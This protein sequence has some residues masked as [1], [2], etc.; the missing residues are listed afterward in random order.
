MSLPIFTLRREE[1]RPEGVFGELR[2]EFAECLMFTLEHAYRYEDGEYYAKIPEGS[3]LC[4]RTRRTLVDNPRAED[5][6]WTFE[7]TGIPGHSGILF[8]AGNYNE[9]SNG[10]ILL[11]LGFGRRSN[12]GKRITKSKDAFNKFMR[13]MEGV[14]EFKLEVEGK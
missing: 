10:C 1:V 6:F 13:M 12:G 5:Y 2:D 8:H 11:G 3:Y 14:L 9:D 7:V 4:K